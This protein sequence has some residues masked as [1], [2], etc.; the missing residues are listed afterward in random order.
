VLLGFVVLAA[1]L[2]P[3]RRELRDS[4][5]LRGGLYLRAGLG[6]DRVP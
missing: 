5:R 2:D 3:R 6:A 1:S 4:R